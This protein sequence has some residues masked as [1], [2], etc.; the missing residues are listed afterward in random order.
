[1]YTYNLITGMYHVYD[2]A[3]QQEIAQEETPTQAETLACLLHAPTR[4]FQQLT[5]I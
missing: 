5:A 1:M 3:T 4:S 2:P